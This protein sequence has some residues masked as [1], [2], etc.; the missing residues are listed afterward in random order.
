MYNKNNLPSKDKLL[1]I[2]DCSDEIQKKLKNL[3]IQD[4]INLYIILEKNGYPYPLHAGDVE[5]IH[6]HDP[7]KA[8]VIIEPHPSIPTMQSCGWKQVW[9]HID[10]EKKL[11]EEDSA[12]NIPAVIRH[13]TPLLE[14]MYKAIEKFWLN[15]DT[16]CP[17]KS[18]DIVGWLKK[19]NIAARNAL[20]IDTII[21]PAHLKS[22][23][24]RSRKS[25]NG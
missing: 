13:K 16:N 15:Y 25:K 5:K 12:T 4:K 1:R 18:D 6:N 3:A 8:H 21:R 17:P 2:T 11:L 19:Q 7:H 24:N 9:I 23:G 20:V 14:I 10:D 22:G